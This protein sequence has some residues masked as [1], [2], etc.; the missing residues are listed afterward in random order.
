MA[1]ARSSRRSF[2]WKNF[3][4]PADL[5]IVRQGNDWGKQ[6][7]VTVKIEQINANDLPARAAAAIDR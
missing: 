6:N 3:S 2:L 4:P 5:E 7:N 1:P